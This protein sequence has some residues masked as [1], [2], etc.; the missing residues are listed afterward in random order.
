MEHKPMNRQSHAP[1]TECH[2]VVHA[3]RNTFLTLLSWSLGF[4]V[5]WFWMCF[6]LT[7]G[8]RAKNG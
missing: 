4:M 6:F 7:F 3:L 1:Y 5:V 8:M 2:P